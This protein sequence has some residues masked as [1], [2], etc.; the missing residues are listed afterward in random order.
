MKTENHKQQTQTGAS[1][2]KIKNTHT[3]K[4]TN[5]QNKIIKKKKKK[6][7]QKNIIAKNKNKKI[8]DLLNVMKKEEK[9]DKGGEGRTEV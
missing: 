2:H 5:K 3:Q 8:P 7:N 6:H 4:Q 9:R 1:N